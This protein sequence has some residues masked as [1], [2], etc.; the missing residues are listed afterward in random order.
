MNQQI[1]DIAERLRGLRDLFDISVSDM[2]A[3]CHVS[4]QDYL[5][6]ES[7]ECDIP[8]GALQSISK[9]YNFEL[10][11][12][13]FG[14]EPNM[15]S[16]FLTRAGK[17]DTVE[18]TRAYNY[19]S[20]ASRFTGRK[21]D[22]FVVTVEPEAEEKAMN[23]NSHNGQEF[24]YVLEGKMLLSVGGHELTLNTGDSLYFDATLPHGMKALEGRTVRFL[25]VI[26]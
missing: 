7:G 12:L 13:L 20:L 19:Q 16:F 2:A 25:A 6:Y 14:N 17:G 4:E 5:G 23:L 15:K 11:A 24:N 10:S 26:I 8:I 1:R 3:T 9:K 22:P 18:R 21:A